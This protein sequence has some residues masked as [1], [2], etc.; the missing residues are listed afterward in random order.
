M[1][2]VFIGKGSNEGGHDHQPID[3]FQA[4]DEIPYHLC[5]RMLH[6]R[7]VVPE[8]REEAWILRVAV[9]AMASCFL[10]GPHGTISR[11]GTDRDQLRGSKPGLSR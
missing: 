9:R 2:G 3:D 10:R 6:N 8:R 7:P 11:A 4:P 1:T 5:R